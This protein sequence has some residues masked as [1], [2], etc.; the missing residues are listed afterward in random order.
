[1]PSTDGIFRVRHGSWRTR[2]AGRERAKV[3]PRRWRCGRQGGTGRAGTA[4]AREE[5]HGLRKSG[6]RCEKTPF[7]S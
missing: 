2:F 1:L 3:A 4:G 5:G 6:G 7:A